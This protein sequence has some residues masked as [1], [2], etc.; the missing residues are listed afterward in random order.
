[1]V[2]L[3]TI[4]MTIIGRKGAIKRPFLPK[5]PFSYLKDFEQASSAHATANTHGDDH[6]F[7]AA[8]FAFY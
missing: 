3:K 7:N 2:K 5:R 1:M 4:E 6:I 8:A